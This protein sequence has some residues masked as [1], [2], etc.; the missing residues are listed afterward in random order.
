VTNDERAEVAAPQ[1]VVSVIVPTRNSERTLEACLRSIREQDYARLELVLVD[2]SSTDATARIAATYADLVLVAGPERSAQRNA[3]IRASIGDY[4]LWIDSDMILPPET[5]RFAVETAVATGAEAVSIP[6]VSVG[7]GYWTACRALE[8]SCYVDDPSMY[9][10]RL[11]RRDLFDRLGGFDESMAGPEDVDMRR[12]MNELRT[13]L[14]HS[15]GVQILHDEGRLTL[16]SIMGKRVYYGRSLPAFAAQHPG[17]L[18]TQG[19]STF[20]SFVRHR[21]RLLRH[22][23][24]TSGIA[25]MRTAEVVAYGVGYAQG[26]WSM[27][28]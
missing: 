11:L 4:I 27:P 22:P 24:V 6:E 20:Q 7:A 8:R 21:R 19:A 2:N 14:A 25:V 3:G 26:R 12:R 5:V 28:R 15:T 17:G 9:Y 18:T 13:P 16:R 23:V 10:P 1:P